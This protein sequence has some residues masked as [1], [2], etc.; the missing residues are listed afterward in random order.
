MIAAVLLT[1][2]AF[3]IILVEVKGINDVS[4]HYECYI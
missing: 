1:V 3:I 2:I 4:I